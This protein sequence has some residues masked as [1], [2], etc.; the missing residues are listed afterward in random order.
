MGCRLCQS[1]AGQHQS[2]DSGQIPLLFQPTQQFRERGFALAR[3]AHV[4][5]QV[6]ERAFRENTVARAA[7]H[8]RCGGQGL[9]GIDDCSYVIQKKPGGF[10]FL[11]VNITYGYGNTV[12]TEL[13]DSVLNRGPGTLQHHQVNHGRGVPRLRGGLCHT[14]KPQRHYRHVDLFRIGRDKQ[15]FHWGMPF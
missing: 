13:R 9:A 11:I 5:S 12:G 1:P 6:G 4:R 15:D 14:G 2:G 10:H 8:Y 3:N 7:D